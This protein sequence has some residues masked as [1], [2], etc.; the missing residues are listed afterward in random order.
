VDMDVRSKEQSPNLALVL[1]VDKSGSMG[2]CHCDNPDL[3][4]TYERREVGQ[5]KVDIAKEAIMRAA[6]ALGPQDYMGVVAFDESAL[7]ALDV[8]RVIDVI[9]LERAIGSIEARGQ[10]NLRAGVEAAYAAL[11]DVEARYKHVILMTDG[12]VREGVLTNLVKAE[13]DGGVTLSVVAAGGGSA[14][15]LA[16]LAELGGGR[17]YAAVDILRVP[18]LFLKETVRA[19]GEYIIEEPFYPLPATSSPVLRGLDVTRMPRLLGYNGTTPKSTAR[20]ILVTPRGDPLLATWQ[21]GL[22]RSAAWTSDVKGQWAKAWVAWDDFARFAA[23]LVDWTLPAPQVEGMHVE[24]SLEEAQA[25]IR[26]DMAGEDGIPLNFLQIAAV[27]LGPELE[28]Q[29]L[30]LEQVGAGQY[31]G[32]LPVS[33]AGTYLLR[34]DARDGDEAIGQRMVGLVVPYSPEYKATGTDESLLGEL[35]RLTG[36][37][38]LAEPLHAFL[39]DLPSADR[40]REIWRPMLLAVALLFPVDVAVRRLVLGRR[41]MREAIEWLRVHS[42]FPGRGAGEREPMLGQLFAARDRARVRRERAASR[43]PT[44]EPMPADA[45]AAPQG[46]AKP[47]QDRPAGVGAV[48]PEE[49]TLARLRRAKGRARRDE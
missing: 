12:W 27:V 24:A 1:V 39:H 19:V 22:G 49:D 18:D 14:Q 33:E 3:N 32:A 8:R 34:V 29:E 23:Q 36:G 28:R 15:Y 11:A 4:Q 25:L 46:L 20:T 47:Q 16:E 6:S 45:R 31:E 7:W 10:T 13:R 41:D 9:E 26:A 17:Y 40:A 35:A 42:P 44:E 21:Y 2:R 38:E 37:G 30:A 43:E 48:G 5:P